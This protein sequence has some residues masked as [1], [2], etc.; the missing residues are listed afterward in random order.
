MYIHSALG[1]ACVFLE[2]W[3]EAMKNLNEAIELTPSRGD[4]YH[5]RATAHRTLGNK[6]Q[7]END[8]AKERDL[9]YV[10]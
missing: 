3:T 7:S 1:G 9:G 10:S 6:S 2:K 5:Y 8:I 4:F